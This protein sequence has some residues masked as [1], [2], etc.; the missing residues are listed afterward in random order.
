MRQSLPDCCIFCGGVTKDCHLLAFFLISEFQEEM[1]HDFP[2]ERLSLRE[3]IIHSLALITEKS[4]EMERGCFYVI[5]EHFKTHCSL[6][7]DES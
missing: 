7:F 2:I 3:K 6:D 5:S 4:I 1:K